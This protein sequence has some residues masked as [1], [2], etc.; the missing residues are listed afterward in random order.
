MNSFHSLCE[1][2]TT[3]Q[4]TNE[5]DGDVVWQIVC[6][7]K[8]E[9]VRLHPQFI[10]QMIN[11]LITLGPTLKKNNNKNQIQFKKSEYPMNCG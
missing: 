3:I 9:I 1:F 6:M 10:F 7:L 2:Y 4:L 8:S 11:G 5:I